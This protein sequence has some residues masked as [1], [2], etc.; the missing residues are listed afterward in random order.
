MKKGILGIVGLAIGLMVGQAAIG[1]ENQPAPRP[2]NPMKAIELR[3]KQLDIEQRQSEINF[4]EQMRNIQLERKR[5][6]FEHDRQM[7][8]KQEQNVGKP[9]Q[10]AGPDKS[11]WQKNNARKMKHFCG[12]MLGCMIVHV[13][14]AIWV[15]Q[16]I[17]KRNAGSGLWIVVTLMTGLLGA[18][19]YAVVRLGDKAE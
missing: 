5:L 17:R 14:L 4:N 11:C 12:L 18:L 15:Y 16:D 1:Q 6:E 2:D 3:H 10:N 7:L 13:L 9:E 8:K 19:V